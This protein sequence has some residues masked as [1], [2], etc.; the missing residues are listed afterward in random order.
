VEYR[1]AP[2]KASSS[3]P[4]YSAALKGNIPD[5][6]SARH[7]NRAKNPARSQR[8]NKNPAV[9]TTI[10][11]PRGVVFS[12]W[13]GAGSNRRHT[14]FQSASGPCKSR[15]TNGLWGVFF[16]CA[17]GWNILHRNDVRRRADFRERQGAGRRAFPP[18]RGLC[19][20]LHREGQR[21]VP[22]DRLH[23]PGVRPA[24]EHERCAGDAQRMQVQTAA[25]V[26]V[27]DAGVGPNQ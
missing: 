24:L 14:D 12:E 27:V 25:R 5:S 7:D 22:K 8:R 18:L 11:K 1:A 17:H 6:G 23:V 26:A 15:Q 2:L 13:T 21:G 20:D 16:S 9:P 10:G 19:V 4:K 3:P